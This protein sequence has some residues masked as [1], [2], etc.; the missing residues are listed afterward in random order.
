M[1]VAG[2]AND[3]S[4]RRTERL[5]VLLNPAEK[6]SLEERARHADVSVAELVRREILAPDDGLGARLGLTA[7]QT[8]LLESL[9]DQA[10]AAL[11]KANR[12]LDRAFAEIEATRSYF[13]AKR[14][15]RGE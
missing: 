3:R 14:A 4:Q 5:V 9:A 1:A 8:K 2:S 13:E 10:L 12:G 7:E 15:E 6:R 11:A